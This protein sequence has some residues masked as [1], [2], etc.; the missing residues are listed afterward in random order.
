MQLVKR[1][2][3][4]MLESLLLFCFLAI[5]IQSKPLSSI[6]EA[7]LVLEIQQHSVI[8]DNDLRAVKTRRFL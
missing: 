1:E 7:Y 5:L 4:V 6:K 3:L 2:L 8:S